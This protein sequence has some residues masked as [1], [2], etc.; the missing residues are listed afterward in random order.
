[1][2]DS[3]DELLGVSHRG[4][5][6]FFV[7]A[8]RDAAEGTVDRQEL[9]YNASVLAHYA[10]VSTVSDTDFPAPA[11]LSFV[12]NQFVCGAPLDGGGA[13][14]EVAGAQCLLLA[15]FFEDQMRGRH[16]IGW[17]ATLGAGFFRRA[18]EQ[19][20]TLHK[21][22]VLDAVGRRFEPWRQTHARLGRELRGRPYLLPRRDDDART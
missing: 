20:P 4:A 2:D 1:M 10:Q 14:M 8:L 21:A 6:E 19:E 12:F 22:Q 17:Y 18:A 7:A 3:L 15:G 9:L 5:L 13:V 11:N 16:N